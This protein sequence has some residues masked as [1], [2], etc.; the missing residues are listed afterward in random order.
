MIIYEERKNWVII[1]YTYEEE[2][3]N[4]SLYEL[5]LIFGIWIKFEVSLFFPNENE[6]PLCHTTSSHLFMFANATYVLCQVIGKKLFDGY[7]DLTWQLHEERLHLCHVVIS[8][9]M[10]DY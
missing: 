2:G 5:S 7:L 6:Q 10:W 8:Y 3:K 9:A 1:Y 4:G